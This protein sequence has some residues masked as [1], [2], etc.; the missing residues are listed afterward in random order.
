MSDLERFGPECF[1]LV[2][3][4][5]WVGWVRRRDNHRWESAGSDD[6]ADA[7][8]RRLL[9]HFGPDAFVILP[10]GERPRF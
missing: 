9:A 1:G 3:A 5:A 10:R 6:D 4:P 8:R 2:S 7:L